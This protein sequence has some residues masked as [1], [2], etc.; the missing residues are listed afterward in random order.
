LNY[1]KIPGFSKASLIIF[2]L[3]GK[4]YSDSNE[5][6]IHMHDRIKESD[7]KIFKKLYPLALQ[8]YSSR[9]LEE[10]EE[11]ISDSNRDAHDRYI[12]LYKLIEDRD[13]TIAEMFDGYSRSKA[14]LQLMMFRRNKLITDEEF[15][16]LSEQTRERIQSWLEL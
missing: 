10:V 11:I 1:D 5:K 8:R 15:A 9:I 16:E 2:K 7:W 13:K 14:E 12:E 6:Q 4:E 3:C